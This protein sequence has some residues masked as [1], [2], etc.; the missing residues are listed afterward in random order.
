MT[1]TRHFL[2]VQEVQGVN[3]RR[4]GRAEGHSLAVRLA[5]RRAIVARL[6]A[7]TMVRPGLTPHS[8]QRP[9]LVPFILSVKFY[10]SEV[11]NHRVVAG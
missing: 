7:V 9:R 10:P 6:A 4:Q 2:S 11:S 1:V 3:E 8:L 5:P